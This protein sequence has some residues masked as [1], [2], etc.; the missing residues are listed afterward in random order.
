[1]VK[2]YT[3]LHRSVN[4]PLHFV[5]ENQIKS[6]DKLKLFRTLL[7]DDFVLPH[8]NVNTVFCQSVSSLNLQT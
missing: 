5:Y 4:H 3:Y 8:R 2:V 7:F 1:M 6:K